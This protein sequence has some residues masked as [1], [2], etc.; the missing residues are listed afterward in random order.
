VSNPEERD[1]RPGIALIL[2]LF[3]GFFLGVLLAAPNKWEA[4]PLGIMALA[5][6][7]YSHFRL[8]R[9]DRSGS[10]GRLPVLGLVVSV[11]AVIFGVLLR[12]G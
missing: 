12:R 3:I 1:E 11:L 7:I 8:K 4:V 10:D 5:W 6:G 9:P 2:G